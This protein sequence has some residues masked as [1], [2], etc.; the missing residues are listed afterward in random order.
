MQGGAGHALL[1]LPP[2][3]TLDCPTMS[4]EKHAASFDEKAP[5]V[6]ADV[7]VEPASL[8]VEERRLVRKIDWRIMPIACIMYLFACE[9]S[10]FLRPSKTPADVPVSQTWTGR[11]WG[12]HASR[13]F[14]ETPCTVTRQA[15]SSIG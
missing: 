4:V 9:L 12:T 13:V 8:A 7:Q 6:D 3:T 15:F 14:R 2:S 11:T 10:S 1:A 5:T